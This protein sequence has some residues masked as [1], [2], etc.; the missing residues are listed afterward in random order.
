MK[1]ALVQLELGGLASLSEGQLISLNKSV[2]GQLRRVRACKTKAVK[3]ALCE[4]D[5]V[6]WNGKRG[7]QSGTV[8]SIKRKFAHVVTGTGQCW[9]IP[10]NMLTVVKENNDSR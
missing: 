8:T 2:I 4:G 10:M 3:M 5:L 1:D 9:R 7:P 6:K